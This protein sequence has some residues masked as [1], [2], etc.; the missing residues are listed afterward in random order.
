MSDMLP[1]QCRFFLTYSGVTLPLKLVTPLDNVAHR[2][3]F[4]RGFFD[5]QE[6]LTGC[7]KVV[8][9]EVETQHIYAYHANGILQAAEITDADGEVMILSFDETGKPV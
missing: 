4:Y 1:G 2:N 3:T 7:Q 6:Q 8:Y 9:G 5:A